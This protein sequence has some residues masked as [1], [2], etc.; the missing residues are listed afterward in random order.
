MVIFLVSVLAVYSIGV[1][2]FNYCKKTK[3]D[4]FQNHG[5][6]GNTY[7]SMAIYIFIAVFTLLI[8][9]L[10]LK[11]GLEAYIK[12]LRLGTEMVNSGLV[13]AIMLVI[14]GVFISCLYGLFHKL[15]EKMLGDR[16]FFETLSEAE[17]RW[18][19]VIS[20]LTFALCCWSTG[21]IMEALTAFAIILGKFFWM[22]FRLSDLT[23]IKNSLIGL[24]IIFLLIA[25]FF[26]TMVLGVI[27]IR[28]DVY[29]IIIGL[30]VGIILVIATIVYKS[31]K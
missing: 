2:L 4:I 21:L 11:P 9:L 30:L 1:W 14:I 19:M 12:G 5:Y 8:T 28:Q 26:L 31:K 3:K 23:D 13:F 24:P 27:L 15:S 18:L 10:V 29:K 6:I 7:A 17:Q 22:D 20:C 25:A 16:S